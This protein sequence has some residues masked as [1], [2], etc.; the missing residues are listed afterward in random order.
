MTNK[1]IL[2]LVVSSSGDFQNGLL[3]LVTTI[4][5]ISAVLVA[6][7][8]NSALRL[9]E[10][11]KPALII[12]DMP[13]PDMQDVIKQIKEQCPHVHLIVLVEDTVEEKEVKKSGVD[14]VLLKGFSAQK[15]IAIVE[16]LIDRNG[17]L[18]QIQTNPEG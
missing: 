15:L 6:E 4:P 3:A 12:L 7:D 13:L 17:A 18:P 2:T 14:N 11:H 10:N 16:N 9:V 5:S 8:I 1:S